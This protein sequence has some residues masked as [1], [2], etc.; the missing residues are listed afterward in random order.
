MTYLT[1]YDLYDRAMAR[2]TALT[3]VDYR[4]VAAPTLCHGLRASLREPS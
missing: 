4:R 3:L 1:I 2:V